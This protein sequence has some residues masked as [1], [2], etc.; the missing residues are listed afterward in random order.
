[1]DA[2]RREHEVDEAPKGTSRL[3]PVLSL[4]S[5]ILLHDRNIS[6]SLVRYH[7]PTSRQAS[8][9]RGFGS[10]LSQ[11]H[12][13][14]TILGLRPAAICFVHFPLRIKIG[15]WTP[16]RYTRPKLTIEPNRWRLRHA[17][18]LEGRA[19]PVS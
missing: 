19:G 5:G 8:Q 3:A 17:T 11:K 14:M 10:A 6:V 18:T 2:T 1:M 15:Q 7:F 9:N 13:A 4:L 12:E 16:A